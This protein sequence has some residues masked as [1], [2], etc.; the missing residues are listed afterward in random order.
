[1]R[2]FSSLLSDYLIIRNCKAVKK[3]FTGF[4]KVKSPHPWNASLR[5]PGFCSLPWRTG[6]PVSWRQR[7]SELLAVYLSEVLKW[8]CSQIIMPSYRHRPRI[9][10]EAKRIIDS[11]SPLHHPARSCPACAPERNK[12]TKGFS[13]YSVCRFTPTSL[14]G[15]FPAARLLL[16]SDLNISEIAMAVGYAKPSNLQPPSEKV[17]CCSERLQKITNPWLLIICKNKPFGQKNDFGLDRF[18][19]LLMYAMW[20]AFSN[21]IA[22][23]F[24]ILWGRHVQKLNAKD[25]VLIGVLTA[26]MWIICMIISTIMS[27]M[28]LSPMYSIRLLSLSPTEPSAMLLLAKCPKRVFTICG[29]IQVSYSCW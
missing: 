12:A 15:A 1:M 24:R 19:K 28:A 4:S 21:Y 18:D 14:T 5:K 20:L 10:M 6:T 2:Y 16:E 9:L 11:R 22:F 26:L 23:N 17:W 13:K 3:L 25:F 29:T 27:V 8:T 7:I